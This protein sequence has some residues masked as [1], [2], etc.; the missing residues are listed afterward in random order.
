MTTFKALILPHH[1]REDGTYNVKIRVTHNRKVKYIRTPHYVSPLDV[2]R[3]K[4]N[5]KEELKIKNQAII[6][7][8]DS[9]IL[10][11][12]RRLLSAGSSIE[13]WNID[14]LIEFLKN[15]TSSF[16]LDFIAYGRKF[17][18]SIINKGKGSTGKLYHNTIKSL[19]RFIGRESLD[20]TEI[21]T[22]FL[23]SFERYLKNEPKLKVT[24]GKVIVTKEL[25]KERSVLMCMQHLRIIYD[26]AKY[27]YND[28]EN[29]IINIPYSPF[30]RY[31]MPKVKPTEHRVLN[32]EHIQKIIDHPYTGKDTMEDL[33]KDV[34]ILS[35]AM[36]GINTADL[37]EGGTMEGDIFTYRRKKTRDRREDQAEMKVR[38]EPEIMGLFSKYKGGNNLL[39]FSE[40]YKDEKAFNRAVNAGLDK[41][42]AAIGVPNLTFYYARHTMASICA[43]KLGV[44]IARVDE[45]LNHSDS[46]LRMARV[47]IQK[48]FKPLWD[49]N[50]R[51]L[52]LFDWS[53]IEKAEG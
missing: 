19:I 41:I 1:K 51:L 12:R 34:F 39:R 26:A 35:F 15:D 21:T 2:S 37:Y 18:D 10:G 47:Y 53:Y 7:M 46:R 20:I 52:D 24:H 44:D 43:N 16:S 6:D 5:G 28:E 45:M 40:R 30:S 14:R 48:D 32:V 23:N 3:R 11:Y 38:I 31:K 36:M 27:E 29:C 49:A 9:I 33:A 4:R 22:N 17:A 50:R 13:S 25:K 42:G 8:M